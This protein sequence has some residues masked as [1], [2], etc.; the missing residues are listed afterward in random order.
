MPDGR[1]C[2][3]C[4][5]LVVGM[6]SQRCAPCQRDREVQQV[7]ERRAY[8]RRAKDTNARGR[9]RRRVYDSPEW[10]RVR[11]LVKQR[12]GSCQLCGATSRLTV[13]HIRPVADDDARALDM[14]NLVTLC[15]TCHGRV[16]GPKAA[17]HAAR[18]RARAARRPRPI[19]GNA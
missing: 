13:H 5:T 3:G 17:G 8:G 19:G 15:R 6:T 16:D 14:D 2:L 10:K 11:E 9:A 4:G 12:D 18:A 7:E 1:I